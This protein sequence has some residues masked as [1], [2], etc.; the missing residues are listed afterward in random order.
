MKTKLILSLLCFT[1]FLN[2]EITDE[3]QLELG[4]VLIIGESQ[5]PSDSVESFIDLAQFWKVSSISKLGFQP[6]FSPPKMQHPSVGT[7]NNFAV[8]ILCGNH[9]LG[10]I[11]GV[12]SKNSFLN[13]TAG[14]HNKELTENWETTVFDL[15]WQPE[16]KE[17]SFDLNYEY[18]K[19]RCENGDT[20][21]NGLYLKYDCNSI[22]L[23]L[24]NPM[25]LD[26]NIKSSY[27][28]FTQLEDSAKDIDI[29][30]NFKI[31]QKK[32]CGEIGLDLLKQTVSGKIS[33]QVKDIYFFNKIGMWCAFDEDHIYPAIEFSAKFKIL[34]ELF[35]KLENKPEIGRTSR[36]DEFVENE[37]QYLYM[38]NIQTKKQMNAFAIVESEYLFPVSIYYN[39]SRNDE[40]RRYDMLD[41]NYYEQENIDC[42]IQ[43]IGFKACLKHRCFEF[44]QDISYTE[45]DEELYFIPEVINTTSLCYEKNL[46]RFE[47]QFKYLH[48]RFDDSS[49]K[50][51]NVLLI[52]LLGSYKL[53]ENISI[54]ANITN[55]LNENYKEFSDKSTECVQFDVGLR[56]MF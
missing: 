13:F 53:K 5:M 9:Y 46:L 30:S 7:N 36:K 44:V 51:D 32:Y 20:K 54:I 10:D 31:D 16:F 52:N 24:I 19:Y 28:E 56:I 11:E 1:L 55:L 14:F 3:N 12:Y 45:S 27:Y 26:I 2:A 22:L 21:I 25:T 8:N 17:H 42:Q 38:N 50:M 49:E 34:P 41:K 15:S 39:L 48:D 18:N 47:T 35:L 29:V 33:G 40:F 6:V 23:N 37:F 4:E 43:K